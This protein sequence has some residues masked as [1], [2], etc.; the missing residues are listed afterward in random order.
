MLASCHLVTFGASWSCCLWEW[1]DPPLS[2]CVSTP[3]VRLSPSRTGSR[4]L[5]DHFSSRHFRK[6]EDFIPDCSWVP[7]SWGPQVGPWEHNWWSYL[8]S[9]LCQ[10]SWRVAFSSGYRMRPKGSFLWLFLGSCVHSAPGRFLFGLEWNT[11]GSPYALRIV[12]TSESPAPT[13]SVYRELWD[14]GSFG[15]R[16]KP[17]SF[18]YGLM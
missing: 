13:G 1:L 5:W 6:P 4:E 9:Q 17:K 12:H 16:W 14:Q 15:F 8:C 11:S 18:S 7:V 10:C 3:V 2:L